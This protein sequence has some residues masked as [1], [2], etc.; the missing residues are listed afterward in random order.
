LYEYLPVWAPNGGG[1]GYVV[2][3]GTS[4][5]ADLYWRLATPAGAPSGNP[6][7]LTN[8]NGTDTAPF[9]SPDGSKIVFRAPVSGSDQ[10]WIVNIV[11]QGAPNIVG[12]LTTQGGNYFQSWSPDSTRILFMSTRDGNAEVYVM[13]ANGTGQTRLTNTTVGESYAVWSADARQIAFNRS[14]D[15][16]LMNADGSNQRNISNTASRDEREIVW[17]QVKQS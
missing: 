16:W 6:I 3:T 2:D 1:I 14:G 11:G 5:G 12:P 9:F 17:W 4:T 7:R 10:I 15:L 8:R 13:N